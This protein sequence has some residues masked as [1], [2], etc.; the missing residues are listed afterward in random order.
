M[1]VV[2]FLLTVHVCQEVNVHTGFCWEYLRERGH[3]VDLGI[4]GRI[5]LKWLFKKLGWGMDWIEM[6]QDRDRWALL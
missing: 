3:L 1:K 2:L 6:A 5:I 4:D